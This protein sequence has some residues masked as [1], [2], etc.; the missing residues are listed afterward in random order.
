[1]AYITRR[2]NAAG[3]ITSYQVKWRLGGSRSADQQTE[4]FTDEAS[5]EVFKGAVDDNG[6]QWP[7]GWVK[8][9]GY[10]D[11]MADVEE[12]YIFRT[13]AHES[14]K[15][16]TGVEERYRDAIR[17]ECDTYLLPTFGNCDVRSTEHFNKGTVSA[18]VNQMARTEVWRGA[19]KKPM[20]P[21]TL[22]NLHGLLSPILREAV[23][24]EPPFR[25][26][27]PCDLTRLPRVDDD[28]VEEG[29]EDMEFLTP[30]EVAGII[31]CLK[32]EEDKR[33]VR[34]AYGTGMRWGEITALARRHARNPDH[35][36]FQ[37]RVSRAWKRSPERGPYLGKPKRMSHVVNFASLL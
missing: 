35:G 22:K 13:F 34:V 2:K 31:S 27:N 12:R 25:D 32:R 14:I 17:K 21:K 36:E 15:N 29:D 16:R 23:V 9:R 26:R 4:R 37:L 28:G 6:Q 18:W 7:P 5:A 24:A 20:S 3:E 33:F 19:T 11:P 30:E 1:M 10:I 8:G